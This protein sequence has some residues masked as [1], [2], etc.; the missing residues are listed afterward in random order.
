MTKGPRQ[1]CDVVTMLFAGVTHHNVFAQQ[2]FSTPSL[3]SVKL[4]HAFMSKL[5]T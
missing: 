2:T 4:S 1:A 3:N 5:P